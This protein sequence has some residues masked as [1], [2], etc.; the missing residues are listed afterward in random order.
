MIPLLSE[1]TFGNLLTYSAVIFLVAFIIFILALPLHVF[2]FGCQIDE[3]YRAACV[4]RQI[5]LNDELF[6]EVEN[7]RSKTS[8]DDI[9]DAFVNEVEGGVD[10]RTCRTVR[11]SLVVQKPEEAHREETFSERD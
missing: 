1:G 2:V 7:G 4:V 11:G 3:Q 9:G 6:E 10:E 5:D 8:S